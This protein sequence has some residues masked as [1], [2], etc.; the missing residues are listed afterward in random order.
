MGVCIP[1][2]HLATPLRARD[3]PPERSLIPTRLESGLD[4]RDP[5]EVVRQS[6][7]LDAG[8]LAVHPARDVARLAGSTDPV[9]LACARVACCWP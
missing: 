8:E 1:G 7:A 2:R 9:P 3:P 4:G 5:A 6:L